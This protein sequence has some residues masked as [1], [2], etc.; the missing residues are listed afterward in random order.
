MLTE[1]G[2]GN[3]MHQN[4]KS[5]LEQLQKLIGMCKDILTL[6]YRKTRSAF[7]RARQLIITE[8]KNAV[9]K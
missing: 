6:Y 8:N 3:F 1:S 4:Q 7:E 9:S 5:V 2:V